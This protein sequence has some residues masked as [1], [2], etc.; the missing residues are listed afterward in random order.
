MGSFQSYQS[1]PS[2][3]SSS[4]GLNHANSGT[5]LLSKGRK[6]RRLLDKLRR[7]SKSDLIAQTSNAIDPNKYQGAQNPFGGENQ[8]QDRDHHF[9]SAD[10][11][12]FETNVNK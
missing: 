12:E 8:N 7:P 11:G 6:S 10:L 5:S 9:T 3:T 2:A 1:S 4:D